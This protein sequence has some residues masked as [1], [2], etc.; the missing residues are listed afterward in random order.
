MSEQEDIAPITHAPTTGA[1]DTIPVVDDAN[2]APEGYD[3]MRDPDSDAQ[4]QKDEAEAADPSNILEGERLRHAK[5]VQS[6]VEPG[7]EE[8]L[9]EE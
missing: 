2:V 9:P 3:S 8:G 5:P 7:D 4:L 1:S 6:Y